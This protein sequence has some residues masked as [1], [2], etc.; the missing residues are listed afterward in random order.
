MPSVAVSRSIKSTRLP[1]KERSWPIAM[2]APVL[3]VP[4]FPLIMPITSAARPFISGL[5]QRLEPDYDSL[6][7]RVQKATQDMPC[8]PPEAAAALATMGDVAR[9]CSPRKRLAK[10]EA[11]PL[12]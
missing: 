4:P 11:R 12:L 6:I 5:A 8:H 10:R 9:I 3:P 1:T 7:H 2:Q